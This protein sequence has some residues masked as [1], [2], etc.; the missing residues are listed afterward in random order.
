MAK[1]DIQEVKEP[2]VSAYGTGTTITIPSMQD[3]VILKEDT[4]TQQFG[5]SEAHITVTNP[6]N[7]TVT[8]A[9]RQAD[10]GEYTLSLSG[11]YAIRYFGKTYVRY[12]SGESPRPQEFSYTYYVSAVQNQYPLKP[13]S[14]KEVI[15][16][17]FDI[18]TPLVVKRN[19]D[20][21]ATYI[22]PPR[23]KLGYKYPENTKA[24]KEERA[25]LNQ[26]SPEFTFTN[27]TVRECL[28]LIGGFIH[29]E[30][31]LIN[32][33]TTWIFDR[34]GEPDIATYRQNLSGEVTPL[35]KHP[36]KAKRHVYDIGV[37]CTEIESNVDNFVNRLD[38]LGG[39][40]TEPYRGG[41]LS[42]RTDT[43]Y[44][45]LED[46]EQG[47]SGLYFPTHEGVMDVT[48]FYCIDVE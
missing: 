7:E 30:P 39:T 32:N 9:D 10:S 21:T 37:A 23:Y 43:A 31:R 28:Q 1:R 4:S 36:Y 33:C 16:R 17:L 27:M 22:K 3:T 5:F 2:Y 48:S 11:S 38:K 47:E 8:I 6:N 26:T 42:L 35:S 13:P 18:E 19:P 40:I 41:A 46:G 24:G 20:N 25:L 14:I 44:L 15:E 12:S 34:Y 29:A 45:R